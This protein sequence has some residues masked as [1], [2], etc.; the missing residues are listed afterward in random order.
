[1]SIVDTSGV[2]GYLKVAKMVMDAD[3]TLVV[4][5]SNG[6]LKSA[7]LTATTLVA[8]SVYWDNPYD[9]Y[10]ADN[11]VYVNFPLNSNLTVGSIVVE[12]TTDLSGSVVMD[13]LTTNLIESDTLVGSQGT[14][15]GTLTGSDGFTI[16]TANVTG[17]LA[18]TGAPQ[19][20]TV[21]VDTLVTDS[22]YF[23]ELSIANGSVT[24][25]LS[26]NTECTKILNVQGNVFLTDPYVEA[27][28]IINTNA[29][30]SKNLCV[31]ESKY[32][33]NDVSVGGPDG[34]GA[35]QMW[36]GSGYADPS[37]EIISLYATQL[38]AL[39]NLI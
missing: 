26:G 24:V 29:C 22:L 28:I 18:L 15:D 7:S 34:S 30:I 21:I 16:A 4:D 2:F 5:A 33:G 23:E 6:V 9:P 11:D 8:D 36:D 3:S 27:N 13:S 25:D 17:N 14:V 37:G 38:Y 10:N 12:G 31:V 19:V 20:D 32:I 1:M 39:L 35:F